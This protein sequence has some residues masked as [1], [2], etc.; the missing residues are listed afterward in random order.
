MLAQVATFEQPKS[1]AFVPELARGLTYIEQLTVISRIQCEKPDVPFFYKAD[2][3][4]SVVQFEK[5][6]CR[7]WSCESCGAR[8]A[9]R[10]IARIIKGCNIHDENWSFLTITAHRKWRGAEA[11]L[12]NLRKNWPKLRKRMAR[13]AK[14]L[15]KELFYVRVW[16]AHKDGSFHMHTAA[17]VPV[18]T[19]WL[20]DNA[21]KCG[22]GYQAKSDKVKNAG[23]VAGYISKYMLK[24]MP[25]ATMYPRGA[26]RIEVSANWVKWN[27]KESDWNV[28][29]TLGEAAMRR[30]GFKLRGYRVLDLPLR[31][32]E[33]DREKNFDANERTLENVQDSQRASIRAG[34]CDGG[35]EHTART[36]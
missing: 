18:T 34:Y 36:K 20:K 11:S 16:E 23:Q 19:K 14:K 10:W 7:M 22:L 25:H 32:A 24:S 2:D 9:K 12:K 13:L 29:L 5:G 28:C 30:D 21:A 35:T 33:K 1:L 17:N 27:E 26:R 4:Q 3:T 31:N 15:G 6:T 8:N